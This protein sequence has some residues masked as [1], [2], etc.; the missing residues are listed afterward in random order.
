[1]TRRIVVLHPDGRETVLGAVPSMARIEAI[2]GGPAERVTVL[3]HLEGE[4]GVYTTMF[5]HESGLLDRLPRNPKATE[6][7]QRNART[8][9]AGA[10]NPFRAID[11][12][13]LARLPNPSRAV[14]VTPEH[15]IAAGY[16]DDPWIAG[17][18][19]LFEG[20]TREEV[21][22]AL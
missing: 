18:A 5:V 19:V 16:K 14:D 4:R 7:Y 10:E 15:A 22:A 13:W 3:D 12:A 11:E 9:F 1:M 2:I 20:W 17:T 6:A 8:F 21:D